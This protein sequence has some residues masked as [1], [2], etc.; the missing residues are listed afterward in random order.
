M[1]LKP[2]LATSVRFL[3]LQEQRMFQ[4]REKVST[5]S[6]PQNSP[7]ERKKRAL[8]LAFSY[9]YSEQFKKTTLQNK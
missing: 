7:H 6:K 9:F 1:S 4:K 8:S 3:F 5:K 2:G